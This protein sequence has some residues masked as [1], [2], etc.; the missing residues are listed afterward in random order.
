MQN[1]SHLCLLVSC[2]SKIT[3]QAFNILPLP[4]NYF[5][6]IYLLESSLLMSLPDA[7]HQP[8]LKEQG[9]YFCTLIKRLCLSAAV[10]NGNSVVIIKAWWHCLTGTATDGPWLWQCRQ[11]TSWRANFRE[12]ETWKTAGD[13][14]LIVWM[15]LGDFWTCMRW[16]KRGCALIMSLGKLYMQ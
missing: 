7:E 10:V 16:L 12:L 13:R 11:I 2:R 14:L 6:H 4:T 5:G 9:F 15:W 3:K 8:L 1:S